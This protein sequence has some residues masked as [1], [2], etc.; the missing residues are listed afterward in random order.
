MNNIKIKIDDNT[1]DVECLMV[2]EKDGW[3]TI[4]FKPPV[5]IEAGQTVEIFY[6][7]AN[8]PSSSE[9]GYCGV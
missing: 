9:K 2:G 6:D 7:P 4:T 3:L 1:V 5:E 8:L